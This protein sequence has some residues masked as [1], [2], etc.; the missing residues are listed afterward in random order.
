MSVVQ[1]LL[2]ALLAFASPEPVETAAPFETSCESSG[3]VSEN[4]TWQSGSGV[5]ES[6]LD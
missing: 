1:V 4:P 3:V 6:A 5:C 2:R